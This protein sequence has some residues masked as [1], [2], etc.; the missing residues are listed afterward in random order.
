MALN[1]PSPISCNWEASPSG[2]VKF[3]VDGAAAVNLVGCASTLREESGNIRIIFSDPLTPLGSD[4]AE[5]M[6]IF[7]ALDIFREV[8][9]IGKAHLIIESDSKVALTWISVKEKMP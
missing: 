7:T 5:I 1:A 2:S 4:F 3:T 8:S 9:W 6:V